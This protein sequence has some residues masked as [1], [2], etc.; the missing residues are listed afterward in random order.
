M[1]VSNKKRKAVLRGY[2]DKSVKQLADDLDLSA[3]EVKSV[4]KEEGKFEEDTPK[5]DV[6]GWYQGGVLGYGKGRLAFFGEAGMFTAQIIRPQ[7]IKFGMNRTIAKENPQF[8]LNI[9]HWLSGIL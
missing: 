1:A 7:G 8:L 6:E 4:L 9:F 3:R 5:I 2:P